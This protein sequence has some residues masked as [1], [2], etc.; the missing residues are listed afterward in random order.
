MNISEPVGIKGMVLQL[1]RPLILA[2]LECWKDLPIFLA[3]D[4]IFQRNGVGPILEKDENL[5]INM[6]EKQLPKTEEKK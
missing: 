5:I 3:R 2:G 1:V 4:Y 6:I